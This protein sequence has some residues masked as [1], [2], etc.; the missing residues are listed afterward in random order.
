MHKG[1]LRNKKSVEYLFKKYI[2]GRKTIDCVIHLAGLKDVADSFIR[3]FDY[4]QT[5]FSG[6]LNLLKVMD[7]YNC[8]R[9]VFSSSASVYEPHLKNLISE[10]C[11]LEPNSPYGKTKLSVEYLIGDICKNYKNWKS[12]ILRY[13]NPIGAHF[14]G[15]IGE[16][17]V[18]NP[19]N[20]FPILLNVASRKIKYLNIFGDD[21][22][23][24]DGTTVRDYLHVN[25]LALGHIQAMN[26][27]FVEGDKNVSYLNLG[28][29]HGI[30]I[31]QLIKTFEK[32]TSIKIPYKFKPRR[33]GDVAVRIADP[34]L[35]GEMI[36]WKP[37]N[38]IEDMCLDGWRWQKI[39]QMDIDNIMINELN[40]FLLIN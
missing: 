22:D 32:V 10:D 8:N 33:I 37:T 23:T 16:A 6:T 27:L 29:G 36:N 7:L 40:A 26:Y 39:I 3:P 9:I 28:L 19:C 11:K 31:I 4:W 24:V 2:K 25:D 17:S 18:N 13:F 21:W 38:N 20:I 1:D 15:M 5:N 35:A 12:I 30:S 34:K 14:S